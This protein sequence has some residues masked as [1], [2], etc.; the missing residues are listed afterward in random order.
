MPKSTPPGHAMLAN[1]LVSIVNGRFQ[2][3]QAASP[4]IIYQVPPVQPAKLAVQLVI[5]VLPIALVV[6]PGISSQVLFVQPAHLPVLLVS[7]P[8]QIV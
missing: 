6:I 4:N 1:L 5:L 7:L 8:Q 3:A 2:V